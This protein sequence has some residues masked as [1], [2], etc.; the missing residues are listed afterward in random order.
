M[1]GFSPPLLFAFPIHSFPR[2]E[3]VSSIF[4]NIHC[5]IFQFFFFS[6]LC[7]FS[8]RSLCEFASFYLGCVD[9]TSS[10]KLRMK[11]RKRTSNSDFSR[12]CIPLNC[13]RHSVCILCKFFFSLRETKKYGRSSVAWFCFDSSHFQCSSRFITTVWLSFHNAAFFLSLDR[14]FARRFVLKLLAF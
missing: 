9:Q 7:L 14:L 13:S 12:L 11:D 1:F 2:R 10:S 3:C 8:I 5:F 6:F 4:V